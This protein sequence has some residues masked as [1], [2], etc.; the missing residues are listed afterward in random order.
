[1][2]KKIIEVN[3]LLAQ[4]MLECHCSACEELVRETL[5]PSEAKRFWGSA[6]RL[7]RKQPTKTDGSE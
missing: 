5:T 4:A 7:I 2:T 6:C 3:D 1:M